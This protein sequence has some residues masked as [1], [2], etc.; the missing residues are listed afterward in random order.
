M[1]QTR[2]FDCKL[3]NIATTGQLTIRTSSPRCSLPVAAVVEVEE[4]PLEVE[5]DEAVPSESLTFETSDEFL[6]S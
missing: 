5:A 6:V 3:F 1:S 2:T 4:V